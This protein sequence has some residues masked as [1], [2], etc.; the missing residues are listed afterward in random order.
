[1]A[2]VVHVFSL[3]Y[4]AELLGDDEDWLHDISVEMEPEDGFKGVRGDGDEYTP[5]FTDFGIKTCASSSKSTIRMWR[6]TQ[7]SRQPKPRSSPA[8]DYPHLLRGMNHA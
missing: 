5:A 6:P 8:F 3:A 2:A 1:M 4:V 7:K